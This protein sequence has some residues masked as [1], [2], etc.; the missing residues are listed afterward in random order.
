MGFQ[1]AQDSKARFEANAEQLAGVLGHVARKRR[2]H[3]YCSGL[4]MSCPRKSVEP[5]AAITAP[6]PER[7]RAQHLSLLHFVGKGDWS[8]EKVLAK[9][10]ELVLP[11]MERRE[12]PD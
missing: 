1:S 12:A 3:D 4:M 7:V 9:V 2:L 8:D 10:R 11:I 5:M 6:A